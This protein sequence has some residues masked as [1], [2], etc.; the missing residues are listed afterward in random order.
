MSPQKGEIWMVRFDPKIGSEIG[1]KRPAVVMS[2]DSIGILPLRI[3]V[4]ITSWQEKFSSA[5]WLIKI[6]KD[7]QNNLK[8]DSAADTFQIKS[9]SNDRFINKIGNLTDSEIK[10]IKMGI[11][12]CLG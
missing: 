9:I 5:P 10:E 2:S 12:L 11:N 3:V 1:K 7:R 6:E 4:P 8:N